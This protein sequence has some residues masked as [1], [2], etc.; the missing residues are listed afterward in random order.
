MNSV[1]SVST[2]INIDVEMDMSASTGGNDTSLEIKMTGEGVLEAVLDNFAAHQVMKMNVSLYNVDQ[3]SSTET[4]MIADANNSKK[5]DVYTNSVSNDAESG[6]SHTSMDMEDA[7][8][9][10]NLNLYNL[11]TN[12]KDSF[13]LEKKT[14]QFEGS[15]CYVVNAKLGFKDIASYVG[16]SLSQLN[17]DENSDLKI[18]TVYYIDKETKEV[19]GAE[20]DMADTMKSLLEESAQQSSNTGIKINIKAFKVTSENTYNTVTSIDIPKEV[21]EAAN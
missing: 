4:Y 16:E 2:N 17:V 20:V 21:T 11:Y 14:K 3:A 10:L 18:D 13:S 15:E 5:V 12:S 8:Q 6:W 1:K 19:K 9:N 7:S